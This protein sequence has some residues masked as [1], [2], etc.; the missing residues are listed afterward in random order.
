MAIG[1]EA[2]TGRMMELLYGE[3]SDDERA[4]IDAHLDGCTGCR[5]ELAELQQT[6]ALARQALAADDQPPPTSLHEAILRAAAEATGPPRPVASQESAA[7]LAAAAAEIPPP[8]AETSEE[9]PASRALEEPPASP[10]AAIE[11]PAGRPVVGPTFWVRFRSRWTL[12]T[13]ATVGAVA[14][15]LLASRIFL[16]PDRIYL[17][18]RQG[19]RATPPEAPAAQPSAGALRSE[20]PESPAG[21]QPSAA[22]AMPAPTARAAGAPSEKPPGAD[23]AVQAAGRPGES[24]PAVPV[25]D[26]AASLSVSAR[27]TAATAESP[28]APAQAPASAQMPGSAPVPSPAPT[29]APASAQ[30]P[31]TAPANAPALANA[32]APTPPT[33]PPIAL[34]TAPAAAAAPPAAAPAAAAPSAPPPSDSD[35]RGFAQP[36]PPRTATPRKAED[37][38]LE[39]DGVAEDLLEGGEGEHRGEHHGAGSPGLGAGTSASS[40]KPASA[41]KGAGA[42]A[43]GPAGSSGAA[44]GPPMAAKQKRM[45]SDSPLEAEERPAG[46]DK[47][48]RKETNPAVVRADR[49]FTDERWTLAAAAYR[50]LIRRDPRNADAGRWRQRLAAAEAERT[51]LPAAAPPR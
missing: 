8:R 19:L 39:G 2:V 24:R 25:N 32:P 50:E 16:E 36:P 21:L 15:F 26:N 22:K 10:P 7:P 13:L 30:T 3:L 33:G 23:L 45:L 1:C 38:L 17:R 43:A 46:G 37:D 34:S 51:I 49:L 48:A 14:V 4:A 6:R 31:A 47:K 18:G 11:D 42:R 28:G 12:P 29:P 41:P 35:N 44:G 9:L 20:S 27:A 40:R 5:S